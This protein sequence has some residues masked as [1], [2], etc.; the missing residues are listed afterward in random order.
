MHLF[1]AGRLRNHRGSMLTVAYLLIFVLVTLGAVFV[2]ISSNEGRLAEREK[3]MALALANAEA[4]IERAMYD[5]RL[6]FT[7][8]SGTPS[9]SDGSISSYTIGPDTS[10]Y[11]TIPYASTSLNGG[12]YT[13]Q[14]KNVTGATDFAW[15]KSTGTVGDISQTIEIYANMYSISPWNNAIFAGAGAAGAMVN[16]NVNIRGS[17]HI[18]GSGLSSTDYAVILGGT[19]ELVGNNYNGLAASLS[20]K[21]PAL[22]TTTYGGETVSTL[23]A[24]LRVKKGKISLSGS[25][26]VGEP[27]IAGNAVKE[28]VDGSYVTN[29]FGGSQGTGSVYSDNGWSNGYDLGDTVVFPSLSDPYPGYATYQAYLEA[30]A[31]V[32]S[33]ASSLA[34]LAAINPNSNFNFTDT[35]NG[36]GSIIMDGNGNMTISG[37]V[38]VNGAVN[39]NIDGSDKTVT[40]SGSGSILATGNSSIN[41]DLVTNGNSSFP[42]NVLG[43]MTPGTITFNEANID[44]MGLFYGETSIVCQKQTD[45]MGTFVSNYFDM[46]TNVPSIFQVPSVIN[47]LPPGLIGQAATWMIQTIMW[48]KL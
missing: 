46:G 18:L 36:K 10:N 14:L 3:R 13:V 4:G 6:D 42:T 32:I 33:D 1:S 38:Y 26:T 9:W 43:F 27:N 19:A 5:L 11:Y 31:L 15:V 20:A 35:L 25:A 47:N 41:V 22:S 12:S 40:Y 23:N 34:A 21:V 37:I 17:V 7:N 8:A 2:V 44:V 30:N 45:V 24:K 28:T 29:G 39:M 48:R 16:G